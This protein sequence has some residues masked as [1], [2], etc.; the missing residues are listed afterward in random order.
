MGWLLLVGVVIIGLLL[1][2]SSTWAAPPPPLLPV[3]VSQRTN[4]WDF[5]PD[6]G[7][8]WGR[9][10]VRILTIPLCW[11][12]PGALPRHF[13]GLRHFSKTH[14]R[15]RLSRILCFSGKSWAKMTILSPGPNVD[16]S[17]SPGPRAR[18]PGSP[19][20]KFRNRWPSTSMG[21]SKGG[22]RAAQRGA[23]AQRP[24]GLRAL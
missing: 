14:S 20:P 10:K 13:C 7:R 12:G 22:W 9:K 8:F 11:L 6:F 21:V 18:V 23:R 4:F 24:V 17:R 3:P 1:G 16:R 2:W 5:E 19:G 15:D